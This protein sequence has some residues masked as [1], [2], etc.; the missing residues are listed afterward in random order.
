MYH[1]AQFKYN[2]F[3]KGILVPFKKILNIT[4][5]WWLTPLILSTWE[6]EIKRIKV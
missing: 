2:Y 6:A 5:L 1:H 4:R 3:L